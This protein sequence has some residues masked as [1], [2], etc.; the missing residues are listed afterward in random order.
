VYEIATEIEMGV[1]VSR[2]TTPLPVHAWAGLGVI[3]DH[4]LLKGG[5]LTTGL[6]CAVEEQCY[7]GGC[8]DADGGV[9]DGGA[10]PLACPPGNAQGC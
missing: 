2:C 9:I 4:G 7:P 10:T 8:K 6:D 1:T 3:D 5:D